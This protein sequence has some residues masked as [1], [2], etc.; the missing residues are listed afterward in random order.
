MDGS[1]YRQKG[2]GMAGAGNRLPCVLFL[3]VVLAA[4]ALSVVVM[5]KAR[6]Q[7]AFAGLLREHDQQA[8]YLRMLLQV[9]PWVIFF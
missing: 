3:L 6:E 1:K 2:Y 8:A 9:R 7:R 5:H 4:A